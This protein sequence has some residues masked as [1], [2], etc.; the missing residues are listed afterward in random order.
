V[1][2]ALRGLISS[3]SDDRFLRASIFLGR[4]RR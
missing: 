2:E 3:P 4:V 1:V